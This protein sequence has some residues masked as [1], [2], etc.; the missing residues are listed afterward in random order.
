MSCCPLRLWEKPSKRPRAKSELG[1]LAGYLLAALA[2][3]GSPGP[4][5]LSSAA[6]GAA[7]G[8]RA[9][10]PYYFG[11]QAGVTIV[12]TLVASGIIAAVTTIPLAA[13][14]MITVA[15]CYMIWLAWKIANAP[16]VR[17]AD[18]GSSAPGF[19]SGMI[20]NLT[21]PKAYASFTAVFAGFE[22][23]PDNVV[24]SAA[25]ELLILFVLIGG[26]NMAWMTIGNVLQ[27]F[28]QDERTS[29]IINVSFAILLLASV[30]MAFLI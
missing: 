11:L 12:L 19:F 22:L 20:V 23:L 5:T 7:F 15:V 27:R 25:L 21:N 14:V 1:D 30:A 13:E 9:A 4:A 10:L 18:A 24:L 16:P 28:F 8:L 29:R 6:T 17:V 2:L 26:I 3:C